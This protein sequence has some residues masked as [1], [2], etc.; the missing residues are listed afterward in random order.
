MHSCLLVVALSAVVV[1]VSC[2][3]LRLVRTIG[4]APGAAPLTLSPLASQH[5]PTQLT[6][7]NQDAPRQLIPGM[8]NPPPPAAPPVAK[9][10]ATPAVTPTAA[11][12]PSTT[13]P[14]QQSLTFAEG[15]PKKGVF[16]LNRENAG[17]VEFA[18][19]NVGFV[20]GLILINPI[21]GLVFASLFNY[22]SK[23][24]GEVGEIFRVLGRF[25]VDIV[26][27][28]VS[29]DSRFGLADKAKSAAG[30]A[31]DNIKGNLEDP[32]PLSNAE[33]TLTDLGSR[34]KEFDEKNDARGTL[35]RWTATAGQYAGQ[36]YD[37]L[38]EL[39]KEYN[40]TGQAADRINTSIKTIQEQ[41]KEEEAGPTPPP[42]T[43]A[44]APPSAAQTVAKK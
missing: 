27:L 1:S 43:K 42:V 37:Q 10:P 40:L 19:A 41:M 26:N 34:L 12:A 6:R 13:K 11:P 44:P 33:K 8:P 21:F 15:T 25:V 3:P 9:P 35:L 18:A 32:T 30:K 2:A 23:Q 39:N 29:A 5:Q 14:S 24:Q 36:F 7:L 20:L 38:G 4:F 31:Y 16:P 22:A 28:V 17:W